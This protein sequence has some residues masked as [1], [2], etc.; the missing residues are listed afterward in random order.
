[1]V[2]R[3][4]RTL[5]SRGRLALGLIFF[6]FSYVYLG[7]V[8]KPNLIYR[9]FGTLITDIPVF[10]TG[11]EFLRNSLSVPGGFVLFMYGLLSQ[12]YYYSWLGALLIVLM[13]LCLFELSRRHLAY[14]G[15]PD[16]TILPFFPAIM[17]VLLYNHYEHP[18]AICLVLSLGLLFS[19]IFE[20]VP[21]RKT[22]IHIAEYC[23]MAGVSYWLAGAGG[24]FVF[25]LMTT[26]YLLF[27]RKEWIAAVFAIPAVVAIIWILAEYVFHLSLKQAFLVLI[28]YT[29]LTTD[30]RG[31]SKAL[32]VALCAFVPATVLLIFL[33]RTLLGKYGNADLARLRKQKARKTRV[34]PVLPFVV[35]VAGLFFSTDRIHRQ[36][37]VMNSL[38]R[39]GRWSEVL[40]L[41]ERLPK[42]IYN[43]YCNH[44]IDRALYYAGRLG[45]DMFCFPQKPHALLLTEEQEESSMT[46]LKMCDMYIE[47]G[48]VNLAEKLASEFLATEGPMGM[49]LEKLAWIN[50]LK[51]QEDTARIYLNALRKNLVYR[52][53][54]DSM[55]D[56]LKNGF[57]PDQVAFI[58][59]IGSYIRRDDNARL[60]KESVVEMLI[61]LLRQNPG[62]RMAFEYLMAFYL[63]AGD[64]EKI[65]ENIGRLSDLEYR[66]IPTL[67]EEAMLIYQGIRG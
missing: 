56:D 15:H 50:I 52:D 55:L 48:N 37:V 28:P 13:A 30:G 7:T 4:K 24:V 40:A 12:G 58:H 36:I 23:L 9:G 25:S 11:W 62:N 33:W 34:V 44:D 3:Q 61:G 67:Y 21:V 5:L 42:N 59:R 43:I 29:E 63:L 8:V 46:Q 14:V 49:V 17:V 39:Q 45:Y 1:M 22:T 57:E 41:G 35:L 64:L 53:R 54:A 10:V 65:A 47:L 19:L 16:S 32:I 27:I 66:E 2:Q 6:L 31:S 38:S 60:Y 51:G 20:K 26:I 18:L